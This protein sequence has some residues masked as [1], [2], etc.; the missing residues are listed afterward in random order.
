MDDG[1]RKEDLFDR[2]ALSSEVEKSKEEVLVVSVEKEK[3]R[4][5]LIES[6]NNMLLLQS[7]LD[8]TQLENAAVQAAV[9]SIEIQKLNG[10][11]KQYKEQA[12]VSATEKKGLMNELDAIK[13]EAAEADARNKKI[14]DLQGER[15]D[16][17]AR[18]FKSTTDC[19]N[20][21]AKIEALQTNIADL[22][23][24]LAAKEEETIFFKNAAFANTK[25]N[26]SEK[27]D[28]QVKLSATQTKLDAALAK[29]DFI[30]AEKEKNMKKSDEDIRGLVGMISTLNTQLEDASLQSNAA[31]ASNNAAT[32]QNQK[33]MAAM[34]DVSGEKDKEIVLFRRQSSQAL[35]VLNNMLQVIAGV[36]QH[37]DNCLRALNAKLIAEGER[38]KAI[39]AK[40]IE[41]ENS[42]S[43][44]ENRNSAVVQ[45]RD[46]VIGQLQVKSCDLDKSSAALMNLEAAMEEQKSECFNAKTDLENAKRAFEQANSASETDAA[47]R[48]E[49]IQALQQEIE[50]ST[51]QMEEMKAVNQVLNMEVDRIPPLLVVNEK[52]ECRI[53]ELVEQLRVAEDWQST[54]QH[55][56]MKLQGAVDAAQLVRL[57]V[58]YRNRNRFSL[59]C[60]HCFSQYS[61]TFL[62]IL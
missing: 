41:Q 9:L 5:D 47:T 35:M 58:L 38:L 29:I 54:I 18:L 48:R 25:K 27:A 8:A 45:E 37:T 17:V 7:R 34:A 36:E 56:S 10:A 24:Q 6:K 60:L 61:R 13:G 12:R 33:D 51:R 16:L 57:A 30:T 46:A 2:M 42:A 23:T 44:A 52:A 14:R 26:E 20:S 21:K 19:N 32:L 22:N 62:E 39:R 31:V 15:D 50:Q 49:A 40:F 3:L 1:P 59:F 43:M 28:L 11:I 4:M 55:E 53:S